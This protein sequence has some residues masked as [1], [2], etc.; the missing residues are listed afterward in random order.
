MTQPKPFWTLVSHKH[1]ILMTVAQ[2]HKAEQRLFFNN[3]H[4]IRSD[5]KDLSFNDTIYLVLR[6]MD[7]TDRRILE[8]LRTTK[9]R[10]S[11]KGRHVRRRDGRM[12]SRDP[13]DVLPSRGGEGRGALYASAAAAPR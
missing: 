11:S 13:D 5:Q 9:D 2:L 6:R 3:L 7:W 1:V 4:R 10:R 8:L 12:G